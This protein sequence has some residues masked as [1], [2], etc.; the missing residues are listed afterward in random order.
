MLLELTVLGTSS[1]TPT[2]DRGQGGYLLRWADEVVL[3]DPG[4]GCQRQMIRAGVSPAA[5]T[6]VCITHFR[7][8]HCLGL[9][10]FLQSRALVTS[11][12]LSLHFPSAGRSFVQNLM[13]ASAIDFDLGV[14]EIPMAPGAPVCC[15]HFDLIAVPLDH[16]EPAIGYRL[17][18]PEGWH[19]IPELLERAGLKSD[20]IAELSRR[21]HV[22]VDG[23]DTAVEE[24]GERRK[25]PTVAVIMDTRW[26]PGLS[27]LAFDADLVLCEATYLNAEADLAEAHGHLTARQAATL[28]VENDIG[29]LVLTHFSS[30]YDDLTR[31]ES[32][33][34]RIFPSTVVARDLSCIPLLATTRRV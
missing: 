29:L 24:L 16:P 5:V 32:E 17:E 15:A 10:G 33:A 20:A 12:R 27:E 34:R 11:R 31:F 18:G 3:F 19:L 28:A 4:E 9:P 13:S 22:A 6:R 1:Q 14:D 21:G 30:R 25:G 2:L 26:C 8:D 23:V 7:G